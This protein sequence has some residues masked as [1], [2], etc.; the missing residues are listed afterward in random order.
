MSEKKKVKEKDSLSR[1]QQL[2][3]EIN[4]DL[5]KDEQIMSIE[6]G[7]LEMPR[8]TTD[9]M[10][11][12]YILGGGVPKGRIIEI[13]GPESSGKT[14]VAL[15]MAAGI[16]A[17]DPESIVGIVDT[18]HAMDKVYMQ[19]LGIDLSR[20]IMSQPNSGEVAVNIV[21]DMAKKG[22]EFILLDSIASTRSEREIQEEIGKD[23]IGSH[24]K[25]MGRFFS[26]ATAP[27]A[28]SGSVLVCTNQTREKIGVMYGC[29]HA[30]VLVNFTDGRSIPIRK[31]V[32]DRIEGKVWSFNEEKNLFEEKSIL[33]YHYNGKVS[34]NED[35]IHFETESINGG[36]GGRYGFAVTPDHKVYT[37]SGWKKAK[38]ITKEDRLLSKYDSNVNGTYGDFMNAKFI[39]DSTLQIRTTNTANFM[40]SNN[41]QKEYLDW[42]LNKL[43]P[44][45]NFTHNSGSERSEFT[46]EFAKIKKELGT[47]DPLYF[48]DGR[49]SDLGMALWVMDDG[50]Y[51]SY[52]YHN[53]I[54]ISAGRLIGDNDRL[55]L[56]SSKLTE[57]GF[58]N[59]CRHV[60]ATFNFTSSATNK[61]AERIAKYV[62]E[63]MQYKLP[64]KY[65][66]LYE[67][68]ELSNSS[69]IKEDFVKILN[70]RFASDRQMR[71]KGKYDI[72]VEDNHNYMVGGVDGGVIVH[73]SNQTTP[74]G[75]A[76]KF[77]ASIRIETKKSVSK[78]NQHFEE[79]SDE[80][81]GNKVTFKSIKNKTAPPLRERDFIMLYG[82]G[83]D[84]VTD[85]LE[86]AVDLDIIKKGG[87]WY[88][89]PDGQK[90]QGMKNLSLALKEDADLYLSIKKLVKESI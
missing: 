18:E 44:F 37:D 64:E 23:V 90:F 33:D 85:T 65:R 46:Y 83:V 84:S 80:I 5:P 58:E 42:Q 4:K 31:V 78:Q 79:G 56:I 76:T 12:D 26:R 87:A 63:C 38:D 69:E 75:N 17:A 73:N 29:L 24:A 57:L 8:W 41:E 13:F 45:L 11:L 68:F 86:M 14:T 7:S 16:H 21:L 67:E 1:M 48:F 51:D 47:R 28:R 43:K 50:T 82:V 32:E 25:L 2:M 61:I 54:I 20:V 53:R 10:G 19:S 88:E 70:I 60:D 59:T 22:V 72:T 52:D 6:G 62:P 71:Q 89:L 3:G 9:I 66:G 77:Y 36:R 40:L 30:D 27:V 74:G 49:Y 34:K 15:H 35:Y 55:D 81:T 39:G